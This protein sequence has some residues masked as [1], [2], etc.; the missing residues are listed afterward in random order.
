MKY[1]ILL[2][3]VFNIYCSFKSLFDNLLEENKT[4][5]DDIKDALNN[6][7]INIFPNYINNSESK[8]LFNKCSNKLFEINNGL[9]NFVYLLSYSGKDFSDLGNEY[10][11]NLK[12]YSYFLFSYDYNPSEINSPIFEFFDKNNF[13]TGICLPDICKG[14]LQKL[15]LNYNKNGISNVKFKNIVNYSN[16]CENDFCENDPYY[17][18]DKNGIFD[19]NKTSIE[20][21]KYNFFLFIFIFS[22][23][24]LGLKALI[25]ILFI[26]IPSILNK[27]KIFDTK[28]IEGNDNNDED[29][30]GTD[31]ELTEK[32][33]YNNP[34]LSRERRESCLEIIIKIL[35]KYF[36]L[37]TNILI[38][39]LR[40]S[41]FY[42]NKNLE[43]IYKIKIFSLLLI[44]FS[45]N[46]DVY[47][48]FP[49][50]NFF[51][52]S[53]YKTIYFFFIK[54]SSFGLDIFICL[55]GFDVLFKF[56]NYYKK[57][58]FDSKEKTINL[59]GFFKFYLF[60]LYKIFGFIIIFFFMIYFSRYY[61]YMHYGGKLFFYYADNIQNEDLLKIF[62]PKYSILSYFFE[63][64]NNI[65]D[66]LFKSKMSL[67][68]I[69][70]FYCFTI[71][72]IIFSLGIKF[73]SKIYDS[74]IF[75]IL[76]ISYG[77]TYFC[78]YIYKEKNELYN[79]NKITQNISLV[80]YPHILFNHYLIGAFTGIIC[81][82]LKEFSINNNS[83]INDQEN[84]PFKFSFYIIE[85]FDFLY[86]KKRKFFIFISFLIQI[87]ICLVYPIIIYLRNY[88]K[89]S[90]E[91]SLSMKILFYYE[92][93]IYIFCFCVIII[94][95]FM[96]NLEQK[97]NENHSIFNLL[98]QINFSY[99]NVVYLLMYTF[100][101]Y[102]ETQFKLSYQ[103][104]LLTTLGFF[105][106][107]CFENLI[108][109]I[110]FVM[111][112]K[113]AF[114][115]LLDKFFVISNNNIIQEF[116]YKSYNS[117]NNE[118]MLNQFNPNYQEDDLDN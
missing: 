10:S 92:S 86:Q 94:F 97:N 75:L 118:T 79:Y 88:D 19:L 66:F 13:Y 67:L 39:T 47:I 111:P 42:N 41:V 56:M 83:M 7:L 24:F 80:K 114:K 109:T 100:Y 108:V 2:L 25:S 1:Y 101:C 107:F 11:C 82:Y 32:V 98:Y 45:A 14:L 43:I 60:S 59:K 95:L 34:N 44:T 74:I 26:L 85:F 57:Y 36:S 76:L 91:L 104:L 33:I 69:N 28:L 77:L 55:E 5:L 90:L 40:K 53:F 38:L 112:F 99:V 48:K 110:L 73:K 46:F 27:G 51:E 9:P 106:I 63:K 16:I 54:F 52:E 96:K 3:L 103:N 89:I 12:N 18:V 23:I 117:I 58:F 65:D 102:F 22:M 87:L 8:L 30:E 49:S 31:E 71:I 105:V 15:F 20:K 4:N 62:N 115:N 68:F 113:M 78:D 93:G 6:Y 21:N 81:F 29:D 70:E 116:R 35:Y 64:E 17:S 50:R 37:S 72:L 61:I 84:C